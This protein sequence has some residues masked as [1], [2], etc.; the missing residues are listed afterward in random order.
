MQMNTFRKRAALPALLAKGVSVFGLAGTQAY[1]ALLAAG[2][3]LGAVAGAV[4]SK[5]SAKQRLDA[6]LVGQQF[7]GSSLRADKMT[8][9]LRLYDELDAADRAEGAK[10]LRWI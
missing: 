1:A 2:I 6:E 3:G 5:L 9:G 8:A 7:T 4:T 10:G